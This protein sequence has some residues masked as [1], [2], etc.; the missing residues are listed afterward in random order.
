MA[1]VES[2]ELQITGDASKAKAG[3]DALIGTLD[4]LKLKTKGGFGL[5]SIANQVSKMAKAAGE[6]N[7]SEGA[8]L[9]SLAKGLNALSSLGNIKLSPNIANQVSAMGSAVKN[10]D[11][12]DFSKIKDLAVG[13]TPLETLGKSNLG[14]VL[15][16]IKKL[17][18]VAAELNKADL[19]TFNEK[20]KEL[21]ASLKPLADE[22][23]KVA[24]GFAAFPA[25][26][27]EYV[28]SSSSVPSSN[29]SSSW[30][31]KDLAS[32]VVATIYTF[33][34]LARVVASWI[35]MSSEYRE[36]LNLFTVSMG[37]YAES[38][39]EYAKIVGDA[40]DYANLVGESMGID[41]SEWIRNQGI[42]MTLASGFGIVGD[43][44]N[45]MSQN[46]TKLGYDLSSY[47]NITV[48]EAMQKVKSGFSGEL[49]P[50]RNLGY[51]LSQAKLE[52]VALSLGI[53]KAVSSMTQAEKAE[54]RYYAVM[55]QVTQVQGDMARTL[56]E[57]A[58][59][60]RVLRAQVDQAARA[61]GNLFIPILSKV[62]PYLIA[63]AKVLRIVA[64]MFA[65][66][67]GV[68]LP[69][70]G[71]ALDSAGGGSGDLSENLENAAGSA[72][73]LKKTLLGID[74]LNVMPDSSSGGGGGAGVGGGGG[75]DFALP[76]Y[77]DF[78]NTAVM[79][80]IN[81][82][83][84]K[85]KQW[86]GLTEEVDT[87]SEFFDTRLSNILETVGLI[88]AGIGA[89]KISTGTLKA[90]EALEKLIPKNYN[91]S[92][93]FIGLTLF[94]ADLDKLKEYCE[95]LIEN[96]PTFSNVTGILSEFAGL[97]GDAMITL[98][99]VKI[100]GVL[101]IVQGVGEIVSAIADMAENGVDVENALDVVRGISNIG[102]AV[103]VMTSNWTLTGG[104]MVLQGITAVVREL[105]ENWEAIKNGDWSG[106]EIG[107]LVVGAIEVIGGIITALGVLNKIKAKTD[108]GKA[109]ETMT[110]VT[111]VTTTVSTTTSTL[112]TKLTDL[113]KN[114][115]L[116]IAI[117]AEVAAAAALIVGAIWLLG[118]ELEQV[119]IAWEPVIENGSTVA[120]AVG[121]GT[122]I[123]VAVGV[124]TALLGT[125]GGAVCGQ[126]GIGIAILAELGVAAALFIAEIWLI[127]KGLDEIGKAWEP[128]LD[129][130]EDI[131]TAIGLGT[132]LLV[133]I[134]VVTAALGAATVASAGALPL[135]IA[136]GTA[137][138]VE[139]SEAFIVFTDSLIEVA[140]QL[141]DD[142]DP[143]L[144]DLSE[145]L[146]GLTD[147]MGEFTEFMKDFATKVVDYTK[148]TAISSLSGTID[149]V[150]DFFTDDPIDRLA[151]E[152][153]EQYD[154]LV[155]LQENLNKTLPVLEDVDELMGQFNSDMTNLKAKMGV[156]GRASGTIGYVISVGVKLVKDGWSSL[157]D[158]LG[159]L[160]T[161]LSIKLPH[162]GVSWVD[163]GVAGIKY[164]K[165]SVSYY[166]QGGFPDVGQMFVARE[167]GPELVGS[168]G[169]RSAVV[170]NDQIVESVS[171][172][173]Y[174][175][176]VS[177][178]GSSRGDQVV[179]AKVNDKVLF[180]VVL[181]RNRQ[182]TMRK[183]FNPLMGG[184]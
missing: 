154:E 159:K 53:D 151:T 82:I 150:I 111:T 17:P 123:L 157:T 174:Q 176:V 148:A 127:G 166:A 126:I 182:E 43:R 20:I 91:F 34:R 136:L 125:L 48:E 132:A 181:N 83:V 102:I 107:T 121:I 16:Q 41:P 79:D 170:N 155:I 10:L 94:L 143:A 65:S 70:I 119:G 114:L 167:A 85:M 19:T 40:M 169:N 35:N 6:L 152:I 5:T 122:G 139:L 68:S 36:N 144:Q 1:D 60:L 109:A 164:P 74:E 38:T 23:Q 81:G 73:K 71:D 171:Q 11:G 160:S 110:E 130:G 156:N 120:I 72:N 90:I 162:V 31:F 2:L 55:T 8:K 54:L 179:E 29:K 100:G 137:L 116:G 84:E 7:G 30:S 27:Q 97:V 93:G 25:Q 113:V 49:E 80:N 33:K 142:V 46:L 95:D 67:F 26:I 45:E 88:A 128:V 149:K 22:M 173:V 161:T 63:F 141:T 135:A 108:I 118:W 134:G 178:M 32:R 15:E 69:E 58:N 117:I 59:Q 37:Q 18:E 13:L 66:L 180:E 146:P 92:F 184:V 56:D 98:G 168:I 115:G 138:L 62:L 64:N 124:A 52:A 42:F 106:V 24:N 112:T 57:P 103:G 158:W 131:A 183:G 172:G 21:T 99:H 77:K 51:D 50:L 61:L 153:D 165:F 44:A 129:N 163:T 4:T 105:S 145:I 78:I 96:G 133:G 175:A 140:D 177:A 14:S 86:L 28:S 89:W 47:Y 12:A 104:A 76:E 9:E 87:W 3:L 39:E 75:F 101:K 147:N